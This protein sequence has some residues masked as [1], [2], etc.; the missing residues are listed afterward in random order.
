MAIGESFPEVL[1][2][3]Q[4]GAEWAWRTIYRD[5]SPAVIGYLRL[6]GALEPEDL[7]GEVFVQVVRNLSGFE[8]SESKFRSWVFVIAHHRALDERR[9]RARR[10]LQPE[11]PQSIERYGP[12]GNSEDEALDRLGIAEVR[13]V[14]HYLTDDQREV[15]LLRIVG[16][17]T[18]EETAA[19]LNKRVGSVKALQRRSIATIRRQ[20][21][22]RV[23]ASDA[24]PSAALS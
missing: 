23:N 16:G 7:T 4:L 8:G 3:A 2:A 10:P 6:Q 22:V 1:C 18:L 5:L 17:L 9:L 19:A 24:K 14:L 21:L 13:R 15:M 12:V 11:L 20:D